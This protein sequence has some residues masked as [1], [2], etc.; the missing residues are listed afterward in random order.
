MLQPKRVKYRNH[1]RGRRKGI[2]NAALAKSNPVIP[3]KV[4][5]N[6]KPAAN[7]IGIPGV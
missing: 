5:K 3:P 2:S 4:N 7:K 1:H 6:K